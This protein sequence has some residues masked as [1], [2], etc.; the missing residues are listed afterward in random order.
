MS[1]TFNTTLKNCTAESI[2]G[3]GIFSDKIIHASADKADQ[4]SIL[5][6]TFAFTNG[7]I[8][9]YL[10]G[11]SKFAISNTGTKDEGSSTQGKLV[12]VSGTQIYHCELK[13]PKLNWLTGFPLAT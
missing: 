10:L 2:D 5:S 4:T 9:F 12:L 7:K 3:L 1:Y 6:G 11:L 13:I 8:S